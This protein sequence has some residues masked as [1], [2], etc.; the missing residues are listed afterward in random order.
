MTEIGKGLVGDTKMISVTEIQ[1][2]LYTGLYYDSS[3]MTGSVWA[4]TVYKH[5]KD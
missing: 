4:S 5:R 2:S 1:V 3:Y